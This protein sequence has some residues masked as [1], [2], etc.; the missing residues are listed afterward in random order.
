MGYHGKIINDWGAVDLRNPEHMQMV[1]GAVNHFLSA[2]DTHPQLAPALRAQAQHFTTSG[3]FPAQIRQI[4]AT[5]Q[6][7]DDYDLGYEQVFDIGDYTGTQED[8]IDIMDVEDGL[9]FREIPR[10]GR[11]DVRKFSGS[12][13]SIDFLTYGAALG[14]RWEDLADNKYWNLERSAAAFRA[15]AF[16]ARSQYYYNLIDALTAT[17]YDVAWA[18]GASRTEAEDDAITMNNAAT[19]ILVALK[20]SGIQVSANSQFV[21]LAP[22]QLKLRILK[23]LANTSQAVAGAQ[24]TTV[25][26]FTP[27]FTMMMCCTANYY[28]ILPKQKIRGGYRQNLTLQGDTDVLSLTDITGGWMRFCGAIE[29]TQMRRCATA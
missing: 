11:M 24:S 1:R 3:D 21:V 13:T 15:A 4:M 14:W 7:L 19:A 10:G 6:A 9:A 29:M 18:G 22:V 17:T 2:P 8:G 28:V 23:A 16:S 25:F 20:S 26:N 12:K 5:Y 27:V